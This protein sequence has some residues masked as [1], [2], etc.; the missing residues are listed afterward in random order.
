[1]RESQLKRNIIMATTPSNPTTTKS[2]SPTRAVRTTKQALAQQKADAERERAARGA[3]KP[4]DALDVI[5][6]TAKPA[7]IAIAA[8]APTAIAR[9]GGR[10]PR[11]AY[12]DEVAPAAIVGRL[13]KF[14][15][16]GAFVT[17]DDEAEIPD[18]ADFVALCDQTLVGWLRFNNDAPPDRRMGLLYNGFVPPP[19]E[20]LGDLDQANWPAGLSG[21]PEDPWKHQMYLVLQGENSELFTFATSSMTGRRA[22]GN[23][24]RHFDRM[25]KTHPGELPVVR[26]KTGG[27]QHR[28]ERIGWVH[29]PVFAVVGRTPRDSAAKPD[30]S[31]AADLNDEIPF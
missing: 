4:Q 9:P 12:L 7:G 26:L 8:A 21:A 10:T 23:L 30:T 28:D 17:A 29:T 13:I 22:V 20:A 6:D 11:E 24:L 31:P 1:L 25:Q 16:E 15:R 3:A 5:L 14:T 18:T 2:A 27:F 19:R